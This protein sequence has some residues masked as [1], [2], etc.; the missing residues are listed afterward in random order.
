MRRFLV[1]FLLVGFFLAVA[2]FFLLA[3]Y[4]R[5]NFP[6]N[7]W[8]NGV[9]CT[10]KSVEEVNQELSAGAEAPVI[11]ILDEEGNTYL[12]DTAETGYTADY[13]E[14][15]EDFI[16]RQN[17]LLWVQNMMLQKSHVLFPKFRL[18]EEKLRQMLNG[19][20]PVRQEQGKE[21]DVTIRF[22]DTEGW[23]LDNGLDH[24]LNVDLLYE[25]VMESVA[26]NSFEVKLEQSGCIYD[27]D[28]TAL[29]LKLL[30]LWDK[31]DD[32]QQCGIVYD[33]GDQ[34]IPLKGR[35]S[36]GFLEVDSSGLPLLD[37]E[38]EVVVDSERIKEFV[39][40]LAEEYD[41]F[42]KEISFQSTRG[43]VVQVPGNGTYGTT[44]DQ[45]AELAY[46]TEA[47]E[48]NLDE[49]HIPAYVRQGLVRGR[50][51]IGDTYI[52]VDMTEQK[53][54]YYADGELVIET[55]V[56]TG[57]TGRRMGTPAGVNYVYNKQRNRVL[58]GEGY[59]SPV[60]YWVPV[61][62]AIGIHDANWRSEFGGEI[63]KTNGSHGCINT[64]TEIMSQLYD[65]VEIGTPVIMFY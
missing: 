30:S 11:R 29:Q 38:G 39:S 33:M 55:D 10:G 7:T 42:G 6:V 8:I 65:A 61:K 3:L 14:P 46:L 26:D 47:L 44:I 40:G 5:N 62:G 35:I 54:Y 12:I 64:P 51:D 43:D 27:V 2:S 58:R 13:S 17:P 19:L 24:R 31:I 48:K 50:N 37:E 45:E 57:N 21:T 22:S 63:Y 16:H 52:E 20:E 25:R 4:Y 36:A 60:K 34:M 18:D 41:T 49:E 23:V 56:V 59:A 32:F 9:Y 15:L 1:R 28:P 53:M